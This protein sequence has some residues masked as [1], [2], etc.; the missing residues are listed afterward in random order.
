MSKS[1]DSFNTNEDVIMQVS[2]SNNIFPKYE[3]HYMT[4]AC[5]ILPY[6]GYMDENEIL[7]TSLCKLSNSFWKS[8]R[9]IVLSVTK[10]EK[11]VIEINNMTETKRV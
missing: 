3:H 6:Y 10:I 2:T 8:Y 4:M 9:N 11:R 1:Q 7:I 5:Y